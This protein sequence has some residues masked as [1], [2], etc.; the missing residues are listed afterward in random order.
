MTAEFFDT[1]IP[2]FKAVRPEGTYIL[3]V[4]CTAL[5]MDDEQLQQFLFQKAHFHVD[6][7]TCYGGHTGFFRMTLSVPRAE[8]YRALCSLEQAVK[9]IS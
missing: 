2:Q 7:G 1:R 5:G 6:Y 9:D 4:D 8:L 3:W